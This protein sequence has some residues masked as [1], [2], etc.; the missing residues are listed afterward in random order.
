MSRKRKQLHVKSQRAGRA[1]APLA[2]RV[3]ELMRVG[4]SRQVAEQLCV[5][6]LALEC[7]P[8]LAPLGRRVMAEQAS[9]ALAWQPV[10][11]AVPTLYGGE[12]YAEAWRA[13]SLAA[14]P[15]FDRFMAEMA[16]F[17]TAIL[18]AEDVTLEI[19]HPDNV[20]HLTDCLRAEARGDFGAAIAA[21]K[22]SIRPVH[23]TQLAELE[24]MRRQADELS[25]AV[26]GRWMCGAA[27]RW[28]EQTEYG[29]DTGFRLAEL[30]LRTLGAPESGM[31]E[32]LP[33][34]VKWDLLVHD[35]LLFD[36]GLL[37]YWLTHEAAPQLLER[38]PGV[39]AWVLAQP[40]I[41]EL[42]GPVGEGALMR[43]LRTGTDVV[44]GDVGLAQDHPSGRMFYGRLVQVDQ[45]DRWWFATLP[46][47]IDSDAQVA[48]VL[49]VLDSSG[50]DEDRL[51]ALYAPMRRTV[52]EDVSEAS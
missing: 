21:L 6:E 34:R 29:L 49:E 22:Q 13:L 38:A 41:A 32:W 11:L 9:T 18:P 19:L 43:D 28:G 17:D 25:P 7:A 4:W 36:R 52:G 16:T 48:G 33:S 44:V 26:W 27:Q 23:D 15:P 1:P 37:D 8:T 20:R 39:A 45:D 14:E 12:E 51:R 47:I 10:R 24:F 50:D 5:I 40:T 31:Q 2:E 3:Q 42:A 30:V 35:A 46:T